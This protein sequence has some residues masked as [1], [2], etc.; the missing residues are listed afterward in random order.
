M[1]H[2]HECKL[3]QNSA[4]ITL[5]DAA[6]LMYFMQHL[7]KSSYQVAVK[8]TESTVLVKV[9]ASKLNKKRFSR[10]QFARHF[11]EMDLVQDKKIH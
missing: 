7:D 8:A 4:S 6:S 1:P 2:Y 5:A 11:A 10:K 3:S 9:E